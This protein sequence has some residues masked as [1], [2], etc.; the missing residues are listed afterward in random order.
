MHPV[1]FIISWVLQAIGYY[2][3]LKKVGVKPLN[4]LVQL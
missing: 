3:V 2:M 1:S 4:A